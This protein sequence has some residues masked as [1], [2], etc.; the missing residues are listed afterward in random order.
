[1]HPA[2]K[3]ELYNKARNYIKCNKVIKVWTGWD[4]PTDNGCSIISDLETLKRVFKYTHDMHWPIIRVE[5][6]K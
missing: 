1:M 2:L 5:E 6:Y 3:N 4:D